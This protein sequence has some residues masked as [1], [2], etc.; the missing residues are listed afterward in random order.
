M[1][2]LRKKQ[3]MYWAITKI[4]VSV[5]CLGLISSLLTIVLLN[6]Q[7]S[8]IP[9]YTMFLFLSS[10]IPSLVATSL[11]ESIDRK[12]FEFSFNEKIRNNNFTFN[13]ETKLYE[14]GQQKFKYSHHVN[15]NGSFEF[16]FLEVPN[17]V[18]L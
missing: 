6:E 9:T 18:K 15:E 10:I 7:E 4:L 16:I 11:A 8:K 12:I 17:S 5:C 1:E 3:K 2:Q 13:E 14:Q